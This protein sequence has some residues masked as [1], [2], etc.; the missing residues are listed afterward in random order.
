[1]DYKSDDSSPLVY[2]RRVS[3][4]R[5][6]RDIQRDGRLK[7]RFVEVAQKTATIKMQDSTMLYARM[8][9]R[10]PQITQIVADDGD[11]FF[12][13]DGFDVGRITDSEY[14]ERPIL[15]T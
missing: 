3:P 9:I 1:M 8:N 12:V 4:L 10:H 14:S 11:I 13:G 2:R 5:H 6:Y 7:L 15:L